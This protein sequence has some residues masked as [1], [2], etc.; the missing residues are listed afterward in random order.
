MYQGKK[1]DTEPPA[2]KSCDYECASDCVVTDYVQDY[3]CDD[4]CEVSNRHDKTQ[5]IWDGLNMK[6]NRHFNNLFVTYYTDQW[7][8]KILDLYEVSSFVIN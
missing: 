4:T 2:E 5:T 8:L 1:I 3:G 6:V 7:F